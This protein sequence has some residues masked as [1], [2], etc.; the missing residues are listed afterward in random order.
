LG[1]GI[2]E[3][4]MTLRALAAILA[5]ATSLTFISVQADAQ[6]TQRTVRSGERTVITSRDETGRTRTRIVVDRRSY[7]N[8]GTQVF[9]G[10]VR[11]NDSIQAVM[12]D[13]NEIFR[14]TGADI[15]PSRVLPRLDLPLPP[16]Q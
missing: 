1:L 4:I 16:Q 5:M 8:P 11:Y 2:G 10:E 14:N 3:E 15:D 12:R 9:P 6:T 7:L 13:P